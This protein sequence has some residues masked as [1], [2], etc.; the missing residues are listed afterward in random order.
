MRAFPT[1]LGS[2]SKRQLSRGPQLPRA[3]SSIS[4]RS[5]V[6]RSGSRVYGPRRYRDWGRTGLGWVRLLTGLQPLQPASQ[7]GS[8]CQSWGSPSAPCWFLR[9]GNQH[10]PP[11]PGG[12][13]D[14]GAAACQHTLQQTQTHSSPNPSAC[15]SAQCHCTGAE[16]G[17]E[18]GVPAVCSHPH[19]AMALAGVPHWLRL[20]FLQDRRRPQP[21]S[22][23]QMS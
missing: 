2:P 8:A 5:H 17:H 9:P 14:T 7:H 3:G 11:S 20:G 1:S 10:S 12:G 16:S 13:E 21:V 23:N 19:A 4:C 18:I 6:G 15:G 22:H